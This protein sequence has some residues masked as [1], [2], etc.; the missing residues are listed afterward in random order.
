MWEATLISCAGMLCHPKRYGGHCSV[1]CRTVGGKEQI[2][3]R[4]LWERY[5]LFWLTVFCELDCAGRDTDA[6]QF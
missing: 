6:F 5:N 1:L 4:I 2:E 3:K